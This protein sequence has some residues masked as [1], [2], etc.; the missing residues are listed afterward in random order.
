MRKL[1]QG[2]SSKEAQASSSKGVSRQEGRLASKQALGRHSVGA[3]PWRGLL[4][5][6]RETLDQSGLDVL[7]MDSKKK[8]F[9]QIELYVVSVSKHCKSCTLLAG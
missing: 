2:S 9:K 3:M 7:M 4:Y 6:I 8:T 1:K 5:F